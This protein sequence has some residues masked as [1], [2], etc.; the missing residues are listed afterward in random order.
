MES[1]A[2]ATLTMKPCPALESTPAADFALPATTPAHPPEGAGG[3]EEAGGSSGRG[4][5][6]GFGRPEGRAEEAAGC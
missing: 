2:A 6:G 5:G 4:G 3:T 1:A